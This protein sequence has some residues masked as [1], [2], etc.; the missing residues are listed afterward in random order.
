[1]KPVRVYYSPAYVGAAHAFETTRKAQWIVDSLA[2]RPIRGVEIVAPNPLAIA[3]LETA[4]SPAYIHAVQTGQPRIDAESNGFQWDPGIW[5]MAISSNGGAFEA[6]LSAME[7][8]V[9]G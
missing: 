5:Q 6:A 3:Q 4:H 2:A 9:S 1:M 8:G 7:D